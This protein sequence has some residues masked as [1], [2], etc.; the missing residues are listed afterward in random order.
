MVIGVDLFRIPSANMPLVNASL[1]IN[2]PGM[3][4]EIVLQLD[5]DRFSQRLMLET[6]RTGH[7]YEPETSSLRVRPKTSSWIAELSQH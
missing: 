4:R 7:L 3:E 5:P 2:R 6:F 1:N